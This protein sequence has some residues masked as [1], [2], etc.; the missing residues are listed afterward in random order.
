MI[1]PKALAKQLRNIG[2]L[3]AQNLLDVGIDSLAK[4]KQIGAIEAYMRICALDTFCGTYHATYLYALDGAIRGCDWRK[5][6]TGKKRAYKEI[7]A[8]LRQRRPR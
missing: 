8:S 1:T 3:T 5:I 4:L 7:T 6:P 2:P